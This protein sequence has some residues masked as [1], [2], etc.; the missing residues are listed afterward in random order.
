[1]AEGICSSS[2]NLHSLYIKMQFPLCCWMTSKSPQMS[3]TWLADRALHCDSLTMQR[4]EPSTQ[5]SVSHHATH[6][7]SQHRTVTLSTTLCNSSHTLCNTTWHYASHHITHC[8]SLHHIDSPHNTAVDQKTRWL[9]TKHSNWSHTTG[10]LD[11]PLTS[12]NSPHNT[13]W[14]TTEQS[15]AHHTT[16][17]DSPQAKQAAPGFR[18]LRCPEWWWSP[19][20]WGRTWHPRDLQAPAKRWRPRAIPR[21]CCTECLPGT[22]PPVHLKREVRS[23]GR[24]KFVLVLETTK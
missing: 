20:W 4:F 5:H 8:D 23:T 1:M 17:G 22:L 6:C 7:D 16:L 14:Q 24:V 10:Q 15:V 9:T 2:L 18:T 19:W 13:L 11:D 3:Y 12:C 21:H